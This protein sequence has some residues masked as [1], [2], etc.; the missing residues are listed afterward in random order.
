MRVRALIGPTGYGSY[1][2]AW[3][4]WPPQTYSGPFSTLLEAAERAQK[5]ADYEGVEVTIEVVENCNRLTGT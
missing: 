5:I 4:D 3:R 2:I 1:G